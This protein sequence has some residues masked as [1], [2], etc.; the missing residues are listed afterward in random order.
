MPEGWSFFGDEIDALE[1]RHPSREAAL[2]ALLDQLERGLRQSQAKIWV[3]REVAGRWGSPETVYEPDGDP[4]EYKPLSPGFWNAVLNDPKVVIDDTAHAVTAGGYR[5]TPI[6]VSPLGKLSEVS[7]EL[8]ED[9]A[10]SV[11]QTEPP[12]SKGG[13]PTKSSTVRCWVEIVRIANTPDGLPDRDALME[14]MQT[15]NAGLEKSLDPSRIRTMLAA[16]YERLKS[17]R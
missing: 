2:E 8:E 14:H 9:H 3:A 5:Y 16:V 12:V 6:R 1:F 7:E 11:Q 10:V 4:H 17:P 13:R 15:F